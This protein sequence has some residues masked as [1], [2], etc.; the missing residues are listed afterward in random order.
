MYENN[1]NLGARRLREAI[2]AVLPA[3]YTAEAIQLCQQA[4][5]AGSGE[6][7]EDRIA[8]EIARYGQVGVSVKQLEE[9]VGRPQAK[10]DENDI[11]RLG[12]IY[13]SVER[14]EMTRDE[15]FPPERVTADEITNGSKPAADAWP[16]AAAPGSGA[17]TH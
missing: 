14:G 2:Y 11:A 4:L 15:A 1:A 8:G 12:T 17:P 16:E 7:L 6:P 9:K 5:K 3:W 10:W 13:R